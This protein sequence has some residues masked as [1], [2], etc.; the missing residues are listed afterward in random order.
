MK[1]KTLIMLLGLLC[2]LAGV[3]F[4]VA[5]KDK[6]SEEQAL[7]GKKLFEKLSVGDIETIT[8]QSGEGSVTL[9]QGKDF[10][11]VVD[12][13]RYRA[14]FSKVSDLVKKISDAKIGRRFESSDEVLAR[15]SMYPPDRKEIPLEQKGT[16]ILFKDKAGKELERFIIGSDAVRSDAF[17]IKRSSGPDIYLIDKEFRFLEKKPEQWIAKELLNVKEGEIALVA[18][19]DM[20]AR[21]NIYMI[22]RSDKTQDPVLVDAPPEKKVLKY[23]LEQVLGTLSPF[24]IDDVVEPAKKLEDAVFSNEPQ[25]EFRLFNGMIY[26]I[27]PGDKI[28]K[29]SDQHYFKVAVSYKEPSVKQATDQKEKTE[30]ISARAEKLNSEIGAWTYIVSKWVYDSFVTNPEDFFEKEEKDK[31]AQ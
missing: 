26:H 20:K 13:Y 9:K 19:Y 31:K 16:R 15:L 17:Y 2:V 7:L 12:R 24:K 22:E 4:F 1:A 23:K 25:F 29:D 6:P 14:D 30:N 27:Y 11:E 5:Q 3:A 28:D 10:W 8:V 18:C 21:K